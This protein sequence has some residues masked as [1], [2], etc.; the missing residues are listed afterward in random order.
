MAS[1]QHSSMD[2]RR[3]QVLAGGEEDEKI[4]KK[5]KLNQLK[6]IDQ[7]MSDSMMFLFGDTL[8]GDEEP[9]PR[10]KRQT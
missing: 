10:K 9:R 6:Y 1:L 2:K 3:R 5:A 8:N 7:H 4:V